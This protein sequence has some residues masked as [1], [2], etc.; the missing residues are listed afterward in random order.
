MKYKVLR[1]GYAEN[2]LSDIL[3][4]ITYLTGDTKSAIDF[5]D[6]VDEARKQLEDFPESGINPRDPSIKRC[7]YRYLIVKNYYL[8]YKVNHISKTVTIH[9]VIYGKAD[10]KHLL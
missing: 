4:Y 10:Y 7:G 1:S 6:A 8:F 2:Q 5:L 3:R 9:A